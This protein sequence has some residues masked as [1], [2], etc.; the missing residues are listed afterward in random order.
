M[1]G[2]SDPYAALTDP[3]QQQ[4]APQ[5]PTQSPQADP[6]STL[7]DPRV[8]VQ[9]P[10]PTAPAQQ[11]PS[12]VPQQIAQRE[13]E[14]EEVKIIKPPIDSVP[15]H[16]FKPMPEVKPLEPMSLQGHIEQFLGAP[17]PDA[18]QYGN[19][20]PEDPGKN[21]LEGIK[22]TVGALGGL[23]S[24]PFARV[25]EELY[26]QSPE[27][28]GLI[29]EP[30]DRTPLAHNPHAG[31]VRDSDLP[32]FLDTMKTAL[33]AYPYYRYFKP[34]TSVDDADRQGRSIPQ[35]IQEEIAKAPFET[36]MDLMPLSII[37]RSKKKLKGGVEKTVQAAEQSAP[38]GEL[39]K[40]WE[41]TVQPVSD[42]VGEIAGKKPPEYEALADALHS[43]DRDRM[44][45][46]IQARKTLENGY[47]KLH[48]ALKKSGMSK[49][50]IEQFSK[51][52]A[53]GSDYSDRS[54][55]KAMAG[56]KP[57]QEWL[58]TVR[59]F[60]KE[61]EDIL[62]IDPETQLRTKHGGQ[63][64]A[65]QKRMGKEL[66][67]A[68]LSKPEHMKALGSM[69][70][71][72]DKIGV[73]KP[74]YTAIATP[75]Q[76]ASGM[77]EAYGEPMGGVKPGRTVQA[78]S[79]AGTSATGWFGSPET[80]KPGW[81]NERAAH[82]VQEVEGMQ[83]IRQPEH[84]FNTK[85]L[86]F[87]RI[88]QTYKLEAISEFM[89]HLLNLHDATGVEVDLREKM[90]GALSKANLDKRGID[91][92]F[93]RLG[94]DTVRL[95][96]AVADMVDEVFSPKGEQSNFGKV[97]DA[98][99]SFAK[100]GMFGLDPLFELRN[101][102]Q[103]I[104]LT[105]AKIERPKQVLSMLLSHIVALHPRAADAIPESL[106]L[107]STHITPALLGS[108]NALKRILDKKAQLGNAAQEWQRRA[109]AID[110]LMYNYADAPIKTQRL[111]GQLFNLKAFME[112][113]GEAEQLL[114]DVKMRTYTRNVVQRLENY[115]KP[116]GN[117]T[118]K[119]GSEGVGGALNKIFTT[120]NFIRQAVNM[121]RLP[122][123]HPIKFAASGMV[124]REESRRAF[125]GVGEDTAKIMRE[126]GFR[127][128]RRG[129]DVMRDQEGR[130]K[131]IKGMDMQS[132]EA[133]MDIVR[134]ALALA[135]GG[136][137][138][139]V[140]LPSGLHPMVQ[141]L[142]ALIPPLN[143]FDLAS[144]KMFVDEN[145]DLY[146]SRGRKHLAETGE[147]VDKEDLGKYSRP[148]LPTQL[149]KIYANKQLSPVRT[150]ATNKEGR[151]GVPSAHGGILN[152]KE[153][154]TKAGRLT[155]DWFDFYAKLLGVTIQNK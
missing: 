63:Y 140:D 115:L 73:K 6:Y 29:A 143:T 50:A 20:T 116:Y 137:D 83:T 22:S 82:G 91:A 127:P 113:G 17:N 130:I 84:S 121:L 68:D 123:D 55:R 69:A 133:G 18:Y 95:P 26:A 142:A 30:G 81:F 40:W 67:F 89:D 106:L 80:Q 125:E 11:Q 120:G 52:I 92:L 77:T 70:R 47:K 114:N 8:P 27:G 107:Q 152:P 53:S 23:A 109:V 90:G 62:K 105:A 151:L 118:T 36:A 71:R 108:G 13:P 146:E 144:G 49:K 134:G 132:W 4:S 117:Y 103:N 31:Y 139:G 94:G 79:N 61:M 59:G 39:Q 136:D 3:R 86:T 149:G 37:G 56:N 25:A 102:A 34:L 124:A 88:A 147:E 99:G 42:K 153:R 24:L 43:I 87:L 85:D 129:G 155:Q 138:A 58:D 57:V 16:T 128:M 74:V 2:P 35:Y 148:E 131:F 96:Q 76:V 64:I 28:I 154:R 19:R 122:Y 65:A 126:R 14:R 100:T 78:A 15:K 101:F 145:P 51:Q 5:A 119:A 12:G 44:D 97:W 10:T 141:T 32:E 45:K 48:K 9:Q 110:F 98:A 93:R 38:K 75:K 66:T 112:A 33:G 7:Q 46:V 41:N 1:A 72:M 135:L 104:P 54:I 21:L 60:N 150:L 111:L